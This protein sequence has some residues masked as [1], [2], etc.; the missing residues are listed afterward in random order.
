MGKVR[1]GIIGCGVIA[2]FHN[3]AIN[4]IDNAVVLGCVDSYAPSAERFAA[5]HNIKKYDTIE[6]MLADPEIDA[7][8]ICTPSG[9][10]TQQAIAAMRAG[11]HVVCEKPMSITLEDADRLIAVANETQVKVCIISQFRYSPAVQ[12][13]KKAI[14]A[15]AL[16]N[17]VSGSLQMKYYRSDAYYASGSWRGTKAMDGGGCLMNQGIHGVDVFRYLMGPVKSLVGYAR[18][19]QR[20][21]EVEDSAAAVLEFKNGA[22]GTLEGSTLCFPGYP[23]RIEICGDKGSVVLEENSVKKW[24]CEGYDIGVPV[25]KSA[26]NVASSDPKAIDVSGH[27]RQIRNFVNS[28][29]YGE[30]LM[31]PA[32][33]GRPAL[34]IILGVYESS[35]TGKP[36]IFDVTKKN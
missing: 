3:Q 15:G 35:E 27:T 23:R 34:E 22:I 29:L 24:D 32:E 36:V 30:K 13:V 31:A 19:Q 1:F 6:D 2:E 28:I 5:E 4:E 20:K 33:S 11:K 10:H 18:T 8:T 7:V 12:A 21:I 16:G 25:G 14:D 17:I 9:L 26:T